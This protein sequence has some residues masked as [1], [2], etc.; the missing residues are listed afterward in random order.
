[1]GILD[2]RVGSVWISDFDYGVVKTI[3]QGLNLRSDTSDPDLP[4]LTLDIPGTSTGVVKIFMNDPDVVFVHKKF[5]AIVIT[6]NDFSED[7]S[8]WMGFVQ[9]D[10]RLGVSGTQIVV[11]GVS[12]YSEY[13]TKRSAI[14]HN[15]SYT[16]TC[17]DYTERQVQSILSK[18]LKALPPQGKLF[19]E[20]S[21]GVLRS[22]DTWIEGSITSA[23]EIVDA[24]RRVKGYTLD[25]TVQ[26]EI[27]ISS[28]ESR[29]SVSGVDLSLNRIW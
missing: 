3:G 19:V 9:T 10:Y 8:R 5:P 23:N 12:G 25:I 18:I 21:I 14:P 4:C 1:M 29:D 6:R 17:Y 16:I 15:F 24:S 20:D 26:G 2:V 22:Y 28:I 7:L 11:N 27:D 13:E